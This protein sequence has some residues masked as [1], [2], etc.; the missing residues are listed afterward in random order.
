MRVVPS[1][2][3]QV[4][5]KLQLASFLSIDCETTGL[6]ETD[7][8]FAFIIAD[9]YTEYYFDKR[10][11]DMSPH[12][13]RTIAQLFMMTG[14]IWFLQ[15]AKFD[16]RM[17]SHLGFTIRGKVFDIAIMAR[18]VRNDHMLY[19]LEAQAKR[20]GMQKGADIIKSY[21]KE[22]DLYEVRK[23][24]FGVASKQP[25]YDRV[26]ADMMEEYACMD[27]RITY[28]L[29]MIYLKQLEDSGCMDV[30]M[31]ESR[32]TKVCFDMERK[33]L[34]LNKSYT[35]KA[36]YH[37]I[38]QLEGAKNT[39]KEQTGQS[40]VNSAKAFQRWCINHG[41]RL[42]TTENGNPSL[43]DDIIEEYLVS[44]IVPDLVK[45]TLKAVQSIRFYEKR[46]N[47]YYEGYLNAMDADCIVH[48][49][50]WQAGTKTGRFSYSNPNLQIIPKEKKS[51]AEYVV[52]GCFQPRSGHVFV[53][54]D[55]AQMEYRMMAA[56]ANETEII[57]RVMNGEDFHE[58]AAALFGVER[59]PAKTLNFAVLYGAGD[60]KLAGM[61][62]VSLKEAKQLKLKYFMA[63]PKVERLVDQIQRTGKSRGYITNWF[64]RNLYA[65]PNHVYAL[66]NHLIQSGGADVVKVAM[67]KIA[68]AYPDIPMV[69]QVHDQLVFE[70]RPDQYHIL[71]QIQEI[72]ETAFPPMNGMA[73]KVDVEWSAIS[74]AARDLKK[75]FPDAN[76]IHRHTPLASVQEA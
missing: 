35:L 24:F 40:F 19:S 70:V 61:L 5:R 12:Q 48:P 21:I 53:S 2:L 72:M 38:E 71:P 13:C 54:F 66:P 60:A 47:T 32:L 57:R 49:S 45:D 55:Y 50:M 41:V 20:H 63:L 33:G 8:P 36:M 10:C 27:A 46:I 26:P 15:N 14:R 23:D 29:G 73:L 37:E 25:R 1:N 62:G 68:E 64:G 58:V 67:V 44:D 69:L 65:D 4:V 34:K 28:D 43:T 7:R 51:T 30:M 11:I 56:Y 75:G 22:H 3:D 74:L 76:D 17:L 6:E 59:D 52:R 18:L 31:N 9:D 42:P 39:Y 16:M